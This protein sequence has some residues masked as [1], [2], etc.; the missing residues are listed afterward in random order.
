MSTTTAPRPIRALPPMMALTDAA[1]D[2]LRRLVR[3]RASTDAC[4]ESA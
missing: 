2:R 1:A 4:C 3:T